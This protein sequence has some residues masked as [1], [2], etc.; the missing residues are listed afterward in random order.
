MEF[1][2]KETNF[3]SIYKNLKYLYF[4]LE[5]R[6]RIKIW[7]TALL[8]L[9]SA[10][11]ESLVVASIIPFI[12]VLTEDEQFIGNLF[13]KLPLLDIN[14]FRSNVIII[15]IVLFWTFVLSSSYVRLFNLRFSSFV[16]AEMGRDLSRKCFLSI[17]NRP[18]LKILESKSGDVL[19]VLIRNIDWTVA[20]LNYLFDVIVA[21]STILVISLVLIFVSPKEYIF[22]LIVISVTYFIINKK[23]KNKFLYSGRVSVENSKLQTGVMK[24]ALDSY[25]YLFISNNQKIF[26]EKYSKADKN[27]RI[28]KAN[29]RVM[30]QSPK[31]YLEATMII[32]LTLVAILNNSEDSILKIGLLLVAFQKLL[33]SSQIVYRN[34]NLIKSN[35]KSFEE[36][37]FTLQNVQKKRKILP[38][39][40]DFFREK[41]SLKNIEFVYPSKPNLK[42]LSN[43]NLDIKKGDII[44]L[45]G[46]SGSGKSTVI[47]I[48]LGLI[49]PNSGE[50][51]VDNKNLFENFPENIYQWHELISYVPQNVVL[52]DATI[53][54]NI[55]FNYE[56]IDFDFIDKILKVVELDSF[57]K[58]LPNKAN[59]L[60][61]DSGISLSGGQKQRIGIARSLYRNGEI[62]IL[63]EA[64]SSLNVEIE[65]KIITNI[66]DSFK[67]KTQLIVTHKFSTLDYCDQIYRIENKTLKING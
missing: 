34:L 52:I 2:R 39:N 61:G 44:G 66:N 32:A 55:A 48:L 6:S 4:S 42:V 1:S 64:T 60:V 9:I 12:K 65:K 22:F 16:V 25:K 28:N 19:N 5:K 3:F 15:A 8:V 18:Y 14:L 47:D 17:L 36:I 45:M 10:L 54:E 30:S 57:V 63:D 11:L 13:N 29:I 51:L 31:Y 43:L 24:E 59:Q 53:A 35:F 46:P 21:S 27:L 56:N 37:K 40:K 41:I 62:L 26:Q 38:K 49:K 50:I 20:C 33:P 67:G 7:I 23:N 58:K